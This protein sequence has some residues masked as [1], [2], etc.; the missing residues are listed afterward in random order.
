M[1]NDSHVENS[2][3]ARPIV[4]ARTIG[5]TPNLTDSCKRRTQVYHVTKSF[6]GSK[7]KTAAAAISIFAIYQSENKMF[8]PNVVH[9]ETRISTVPPSDAT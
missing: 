6:T 8:A 7:C 2:R 1:V 3:N 9:C 4:R 5:L